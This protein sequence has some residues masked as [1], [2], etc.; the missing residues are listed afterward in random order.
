MPIN[1]YEEMIWIRFGG[2]NHDRENIAM[3][4]KQFFTHEYLSNDKKL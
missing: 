2:G 1:H 3:L 4:L